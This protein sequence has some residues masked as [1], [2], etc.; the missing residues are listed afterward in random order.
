MRYRIGEF[1]ELGGVSTKTLRFYDRIGLLR[2]AGTD[3]RTR[4]RF[5]LPEQLRDLASILALKDLGASLQEIRHLAKSRAPGAALKELLHGLRE[6][7]NR[8]IS[9]KGRLLENVEQALS[10]IGRG[11]PN[12]PVILKRRPSITIASIR[13]RVDSYSEIAQYE[14]ALVSALDPEAIGE[15]RG[16]LWHRC[17]DSGHLEGEPFIELRYSLAPTGSYA[18]REI[19]A[20][21]VAAAYS[22]QDDAEAENAYD[23]IRTWMRSR[24]YQLAGSKREIDHG[25]LLEIQFPLQIA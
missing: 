8:S 12:I 16:T 17:A 4:Y 19:P 14:S 3:P 9:D 21:T 20:A 6:E 13:A 18:V 10:E 23:A 11:K 5:Y 22:G 7:L 25:N 2:P 24:N 1:A 15:T